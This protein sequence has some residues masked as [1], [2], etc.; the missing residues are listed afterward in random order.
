MFMFL[1]I[2]IL[3][4][5]FV[6]TSCSNGF[7][8]DDGN[9]SIN[10]TSVSK[11]CRYN[12]NESDVLNILNIRKKGTRASYQYNISPI[13]NGNDT[14]LYL[15]NFA[16]GWKLIS[17]DKRFPAILAFNDE[18]PLCMDSLNNVQTFFINRM[19]TEI[20]SLKQESGNVG[21]ADN[22]VQ[23]WAVTTYNE[24]NDENND[25]D[26]WIFCC[27]S[28]EDYRT[29]IPHLM[30]TWWEAGDPYNEYIPLDKIRN[31]KCEVGCLPVAG[32]QLINYLHKHWNY[33]PNIPDT[34]SY[35][36]SGYKYHFDGSSTKIWDGIDQGDIHSIA[37]LLSYIGNISGTT[38]NIDGSGTNEINFKN[39]LKR[40]FR[41]DCSYSEWDEDK[42]SESL[43]NHIPVLIHIETQNGGKHMVVADGYLYHR[44]VITDTYIYVED[45]ESFMQEDHDY[46][47]PESIPEGYRTKEI[48]YIYTHKYFQ[49][50]SGYGDI[51]NSYYSI[52]PLY[53]YSGG[54]TFVSTGNFLYNFKRI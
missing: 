11:L 14:L 15:V 8:D 26:H 25:D 50:N 31:E 44:S 22:I 37:F 33:A 39:A 46:E 5:T 41:I 16:N 27:S 53:F 28:G 20:K 30:D 45:V 17:G 21:D 47:T 18:K 52:D 10:N 32:G 12:V 35:E 24:E 29:Y 34:L 54:H 13:I 42:A 40:H 49:L 36:P 23:D 43:Q 19:C 51:D 9:M 7:I 4:F 38:Y 48:T 6:F 3:S 2:I 1:S